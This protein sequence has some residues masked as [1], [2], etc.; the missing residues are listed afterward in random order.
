MSFANPLLLWGLGLVAVPVL[1]HLI[2][3][4]RHR[5]VPWAAMEFLLESQRRNSTW[6][7][8]KQLFLLLMRMAAVA[9]VVLLVAQPIGCNQLGRFLGGR[10]TQHIVLLDDSFSMAD[11]WANTSAFDEA[12][13]VIQRIGDELSRQPMAQT[14]TLLRFSRAGRA[15][16]GTPADFYEERVTSDFGQRLS[17]RLASMRPSQRAV[18]PDAALRAA[19]GWID[20]E[21]DEDRVVYLVSDF[22]NHDWQE[23]DPLVKT[24]SRLDSAGVQLRLIN[25]VDAA[26]ANLAITALEPVRG[27]RAA[28][29]PFYMA[30]TVSNFGSDPMD[31]VPVV[32]EEDAQPRPALTIDHIGPGDSETRRFSVYF[33][34]AGEHTVAAAISSDPLAVDNVRFS[35]I[36][37]PASV[38]VLLVDGDRDFTNARY[39]AAALAPGGAVKTGIDPQIEPPSYLNNKPLDKFQA[40][41]LLDVGHLDRPAIESLERY[42]TQSGGLGVFLGENCR[43]AFYNEKLYRDGAGLFPL[44]LLGKTQLLVDRLEKGADME[45]SDHPIFRVFAGERNSYLNAVLIDWYV[46]APRRW[47]PGPKSSTHVLARLRNQAPLCVEKKF[48]EG[49]VVAFTTTAAPVWNNWGRNPSFVVAMLEM[50]SYLAP[51]PALD[52]NRI[53]GTPIEL[54]LDPARYQPEVRLLAPSEHD[55]TPGEGNAVVAGATSSDDGGLRATFPEAQ[56]GGV[57]ELQLTTTDNK[58]EL[59]RLAFNVEAAEGNLATVGADELRT[60]LEGISYEYRQAEEF[61]VGVQ[62]LAGTNLSQWMIFLLALILIGEQALAY[63]ASYHPAVEGA[64][65]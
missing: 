4:L 59:R 49:R 54:E 18:S 10:K 58:I 61:R 63:S 65:S 43:P 30:V 32:L 51:P 64:R 36:D 45:V 22:R 34:T 1:I 42:V 41:Y 17:D 50:Q 7:K 15:A 13:K 46:S 37:L 20:K 5:R 40:V 19:D 16:D 31:S 48:G 38:P 35:V 44:P 24:L 21:K 60:K 14:F 2:N 6:I 3:L 39:L 53:V 23:A 8:L 62:D 57:Y 56:A 47:S 12:K 9:G 29:A 55:A 11:R 52:A 33:K 28:G 25:C 27:T 26:H